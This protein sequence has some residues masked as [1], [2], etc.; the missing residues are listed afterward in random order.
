MESRGPSRLLEEPLPHTSPK[1]TRNGAAVTS[2][3]PA[4]RERKRLDKQS[5]DYILRSGLAGGLA[6]CAVSAVIARSLEPQLANLLNRPKLLS[7]H[8]IESRFYF[9]PRILNLQNILGAG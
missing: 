7:D 6:G 1:H 2:T 5:L 4:P 3:G 9:R 8:S